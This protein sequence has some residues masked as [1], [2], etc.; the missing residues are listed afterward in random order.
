MTT[1]TTEEAVVLARQYV[2]GH[3]ADMHNEPECVKCHEPM[4]S[5]NE[6]S[7]FCSSCVYLVADALAE[8]MLGLAAECERL[9]GVVDALSK[10]KHAHCDGFTTCVET[11]D[12]A[13]DC[14]TSKTEEA[15]HAAWL[16]HTLQSD[17]GKC[18]HCGAVVPADCNCC[19]SCAD[20]RGP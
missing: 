4:D 18:R 10:F 3:D 13:A 7:A 8:Q 17:S 9:R 1:T 16:T 6:P 14:E 19:A 15:L 11:D 5:S 20:E 2:A 12:H